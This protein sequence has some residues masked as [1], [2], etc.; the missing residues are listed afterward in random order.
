LKQQR[1]DDGNGSQHGTHLAVTACTVSRNPVSVM[2]TMGME[3]V[4]VIAVI[5]S[6]MIRR[7]ALMEAGLDV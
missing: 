1:K 2:M 6:D 7:D 5:I 3:P 4:R